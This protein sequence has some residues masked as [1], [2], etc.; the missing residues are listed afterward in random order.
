MGNWIARRLTWKARRKVKI[1]LVWLIISSAC[2]VFA[3][4]I[5]DLHLSWLRRFDATF[6]VAQLSSK[7]SSFAFLKDVPGITWLVVLANT[8]PQATFGFIFL[9]G[10]MTLSVREWFHD[11][12]LVS[13]DD[14]VLTRLGEQHRPDR[15]GGAPDLFVQLPWTLS[16]AGPRQQAWSGLKHWCVYKDNAGWKRRTGAALSL[17]VLTGRAGS[18]KS[19]MAFELARDLA[20]RDIMGGTRP[21]AVLGWRIGV[22]VRRAILR[23]RPDDP[24][25]AA[26]LVP[27][28]D[29][30]W[31]HLIE[32]LAGWWPR[33]PTFLL[34]D[35]PLPGRAGDIWKALTK[36]NHT[37]RFRHPVCLLV[38]NQT[39]PPDTGFEFN[40]AIG[41]WERDGKAAVPA[42]FTLPVE[43]W[44]SP[45][46]TLH[47]AFG[48]GYLRSLSPVVHKAVRENLHRITAGNPLLVELA[49]E[50]LR[51]GRPIEGITAA[52]LSK[53]RASRILA[54]LRHQQLEHDS[55]LAALALSTLVGGAP[56]M[57]MAIE[58]RPIFGTLLPLPSFTV[59]QACFPSDPL[60][61]GASMRIPPVRP[62]IVGDAFIDQV[63]ARIG[64]DRATALAE[65]GFR[66]NPAFM[67][68]NLRRVR[69]EG[70]VMTRAL[71]GINPGAIANADHVMIALG[72]TDLAVVCQPEDRPLSTFE[73]R[74]ESLAGALH[75]VSR[76]APAERK[77]FF[78]GF[79]K[80]CIIP[81]SDRGQRQLRPEAVMRVM[82]EAA[83]GA[84]LIPA[85]L[86]IAI[87]ELFWNRGQ[88]T[89]SSIDSFTATAMSIESN[90]IADRLAE[91]VWQTGPTWRSAYASVFCALAEAALGRGAKVRAARFSAMA[92]VTAP[93]ATRIA[94]DR[95]ASDACGSL[96][97]SV[98]LE[99][100]RAR[101]FE[102]YAWGAVP[103]GAGAMEARAAAETVAE[104]GAHFADDVSIQLEV[105]KARLDEAYAWSQVPAGAGALEARAA[106]EAVAEI[107]KHFAD[108]MS[109]QLNVVTA[110]LTEAYAWSE[111]PAGARAS[112]VRATARIVAEIATRFTD[113]T[114]IQVLAAATRRLKR[115]HGAKCRSVHVYWNPVLRPAL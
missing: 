75:I 68:R 98:Q 92:T 19:R 37:K 86:C 28:H 112:E 72:F 40:P 1:W 65:A 2:A 38:T 15:D 29:H 33:L 96:D 106:T 27:S 45:E 56:E 80:L 71:A 17:T 5:A 20:R 105:V 22:Y 83:D 42:P 94:A 101:R 49:V 31:E 48:T 6:S 39:I 44:F 89:V 54:A 99:A 4:E 91:A 62:D 63:L 64:S 30:D 95:A 59:L 76:L 73:S 26:W 9:G 35:D 51:D 53:E 97:L 111:A 77:S 34:L 108:D 50:W 107:S 43:A 57:Q 55:Q 32:G 113:S 79:E 16:L 12:F 114:A 67:L 69:V 82:A 74:A 84:A 14:D 93:K 104:I 46:E 110:R 103:A 109:I 18:G 25:D 36:A 90:N 102:A 11:H 85:E 58:L 100:A 87:F 70:S 41:I 81:L 115:L 24:W 21:T 52:T 78:E 66:L 8:H 88:R 7:F 47:V 10:F 61:A 3:Q 60:T 13:F 23:R